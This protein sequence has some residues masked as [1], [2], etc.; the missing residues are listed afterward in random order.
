[1]TPAWP[2]LAIDILARTRNVIR[3]NDLALVGVAIVVGIVA[4]VCVTAMTKIAEIA[5]L[6]LYG[7]ALDERLSAHA[8]IS[9]LA[10]FLSLTGGGLALGLMETWR[11]RRSIP[12]AVDPIEA[13]ALRGGRMS[14]RD[15]LIVSFQTVVSNG[16]GASVGLEAGYAQIG[17]GL[18][19]RIG[20]A[21]GL[22][23]QDLRMLVGCG[24]AGAIAAAFAAP[25]TGAFYGF[26]LIVGAYSLTNAGPIFAA[27]LAATLTTKA[28]GGSPYSVVVP[29]VASLSFLSHLSVIALS[30]IAAALGVA[31]MRAAAVVERA[32][33]L[34]RLPPWA[35]N[36]LGGWIV[37]AMAIYTPQVLAAGHGALGLDVPLAL[38]AGALAALIALKITAC[39][40]SLASGFRGGLFFASL[41]IGALLGKLFAIGA[42]AAI[43]ALAFDPTVGVLAGMAS[44]GVVIVGGPLTM[45][46]LVLESTGDLNV[47][48]GVL[49]GCIAASLTV[50]ATFG[51]SF[52]T[53]RLHLRGETV[54][55]AQDVGWVRE[56]TVARMMR[57]A[58]ATALASMTLAEFR[59]KHPLGGP[60]VVVIVDAANRY[61]GL[62][63]TPEAHAQA[64]EGASGDEPIAA[65]ASQRE[66]ALHPEMD[67]KAAIAAFETAESETLAV[68]DR[69]TGV[70]L[71]LL[72]EAYAAR[73]YAEATNSAATGVLGGS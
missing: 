1:M 7:I 64:F 73:R 2:R 50:R 26:E 60:H 20:V 56:L 49:A 32:F 40:V 37:A 31:T 6:A 5:H 59:A 10:A 55:S 70:V 47:A 51:Y 57:P 62:V 52:S 30:L 46:F 43:P 8:R 4:G 16:C 15:S 38:S 45:A 65:F 41:F 61:R 11:R 66:A 36:V 44:L 48:G 13:N 17:A 72:G 23:R 3:S 35:R 24:A 14:M 21:L 18:A 27:S 67:V 33:D 58:P 12:S 54:R 29:A 25:L 28:L 19:S 53:W 71:G 39:V 68:T 34:T 69:N 22:R 42:N 63:S 9:P